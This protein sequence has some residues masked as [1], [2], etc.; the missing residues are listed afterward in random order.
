VV[1]QL[2]PDYSRI[3]ILN[4]AKKLQSTKERPKSS[5]S[6]IQEIAKDDDMNNNQFQQNAAKGTRNTS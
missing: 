3:A 4:A 6:H 2:L 1:E 5:Q